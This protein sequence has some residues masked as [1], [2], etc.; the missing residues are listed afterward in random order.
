MGLEVPGSGFDKSWL[1][2]A[3][4]GATTCAA[5]LQLVLCE[6]RRDPSRNQRKIPRRPGDRGRPRRG[7]GGTREHQ[8]QGH[9]V[10]F[11]R[12]DDDDS[13]HCH[14]ASCTQTHRR[15][16]P[17]QTAEMRDCIMHRGVFAIDCALRTTLVSCRYDSVRRRTRDP[18]STSADAPVCTQPNAPEA[19]GS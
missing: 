19:R 9:P 11:A 7:T 1:R 5:A 4:P 17:E 3:E 16:T 6:V 14:N 15:D 18:P 2:G 8:R 13:L 10:P 12:A